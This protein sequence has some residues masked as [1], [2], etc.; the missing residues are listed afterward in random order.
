ML[1]PST[2]SS[3]SSNNINTDSDAALSSSF[4]FLFP[5]ATRRTSPISNSDNYQY[6]QQF[7]SEHSSLLG[8]S[9]VIVT[10]SSNHSKFSIDSSVACT[11]TTTKVT[12]STNMASLQEQQQLHP[13]HCESQG[14]TLDRPQDIHI[15][16]HPTSSNSKKLKLLTLSVLVF[17]NVSGGPF[18]IEPSIHAVGN[19]YTILGFIILPFFWSLPEALITAEL[20]SVFSDESGG[21]AWVDEAFGELSGMVCGYLGWIS[22]ATD[23]AI[24]PTLFLHYVTSVLKGYQGADS[25]SDID[26]SES[27]W[28]DDNS[29]RFLFV[30]ILSIILAALNYTGLEIVGNASVGV[31]IIAM[32]PFVIMMIMGIPQIEPRRWLQMPDFPDLA[33]NTNDDD[34]DYAGCDGSF[35]NC[36]FVWAAFL[37]N[38]FWN[39]NSFDSASSF[40]NETQ[41]LST[42]YP[43]GLKL[44]FILCF[45]FYLL[46]LLVVTGATDYTQS[47]WVDGQLGQV[48]LDIG[49]KML[50]TWTVL[51]AG[52]SNLALFEAELSSDS[53]QLMGMAQRGH[54]PKI[55]AWKSSRFGT[56]VMGILTGTFVIILM[57]VADFSQ[58][59]ELLN[60]NYAIALLM[61]YAAF[62]KLRLTRKDL[63]RPYRI[64]IPDWAAVL[65]V[66]PPLL[67]IFVLFA[68]A[69]W[70]TYVF[71]FG[72]II[73]GILLYF[74]MKISK[75]RGWCTYV[76]VPS[77]NFT[78]WQYTEDLSDRD[79]GIEEK[80]DG[81]DV[82]VSTSPIG[83]EV[84]EARFF[85]DNSVGTFSYSTCDQLDVTDTFEDNGREHVELIQEDQNDGASLL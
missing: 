70:R 57:S 35:W 6:Q 63:E 47:E 34:V 58:L 72:V 66:I 75:R 44:G 79:T 54:L 33:L 12:V 2:S 8:N 69:S 39:L 78:T 3:I 16:H 27:K 52:I 64:P 62:V 59:V 9:A 49:G 18:G 7:Q 1:S 55:F 80:D 22:G 77:S 10:Q 37:N 67:G 51:A 31:C 26:N 76:D 46:P 14:D 45:V 74:L 42:T 81:I 4:S 11:S 21:V 82:D 13:D 41:C 85:H 5:S 53:Y 38:M 30:S 61:E 36:R 20:G 71:V 56:P 19:F 15:P 43:N 73:L 68:I 48:A 28:Y 32:S 84:V 25:E 24:Y 40:A 83:E 17:Y 65:I 50:G 23:N 60:F 29:T